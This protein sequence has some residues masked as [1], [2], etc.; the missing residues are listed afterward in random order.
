MEIFNIDVCLYQFEI[1]ASR[2][3]LGFP[4]FDLDFYGAR[5]KL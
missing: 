1:N 4:Q 3:S 5:R 2:Y